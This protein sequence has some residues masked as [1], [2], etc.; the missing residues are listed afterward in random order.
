LIAAFY[1]EAVALAGKSLAQQISEQASPRHNPPA[2]S[3]SLVESYIVGDLDVENPGNFLLSK[4]I[5]ERL[6]RIPADKAQSPEFL[7]EL[8]L[9]WFSPVSAPT[10]GHIFRALGN[11]DY[12]NAIVLGPAGVGKSFLIDQLAAMYILDI[13]PDY[14]KSELG[15]ESGEYEKIRKAFLGNSDIVLI[16]MDL[17]SQDNTKPGKPW[18]DAESRMKS[19][20]TGLFDA[21]KQ[22]Y[23]RKDDS[24]RRVGKRTIFVFDEVATLPELVQ[25]TMKKVLDETGFHDPEDPIH[26]VEDPGFSVVGFTTLDEYPLFTGGDSAIERRYEIAEMHEPSEDATFQI[27][28]KRADVEWQSLYGRN[29]SDDAI[30]LLISMRKLLFNPPLAMPASAIRAGNMLMLA[31]KKD[32]GTEISPRDAERFVMDKARLTDVWFD[33]P[34][35]EP[36]FHDLAERL[37]RKVI[38][39]DEVIDS[40]ARRLKAWA[41]A[42]FGGEVPVFILGGPTGSGK[43]TLVRA[44]N[45]ELFGHNGEHLM[46]SIGGATS[47]ALDEILAGSPGSDKLPL[48]VQALSNGK[49]DGIIVLNEGKDAS[50]F[51]LEKLKVTLESGAIKPLGRDP[52][53]RP[54]R[55]PI[56]ILGQWGEQAFA[57]KNDDEIDEFYHGLTQNEIEGFFSAGKDAKGEIGVVSP[58]VLGR[59]KRTG[60]IYVL[61]PVRYRMYAKIA[62]LLVG[63]VSAGMAKRKGLK[64]SVSPRLINLIATFAERSGEGTRG[65]GAITVDLTETAVSEAMDQGIARRDATL[66]LDVAMKDGRPLVV[67][68]QESEGGREVAIDAITL[69]RVKACEQILLGK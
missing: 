53:V 4:N 35:G 39:Q 52:R 1:G 44:L 61:R 38:D 29:I 60:G 66:K 3:A 46:F 50:T 2:K 47:G 14:L 58:A 11:T 40:I 33:G 5:E 56:F 8:A 30:K 55:F 43:D 7:R 69:L 9:S 41:R 34:H 16:N 6:S 19:V 62:E 59:A 17:L 54:L 67:V 28:R 18:P 21:A 37:K 13:Y 22:E 32:A 49:G 57:G 23:A 27:V 12:S 68:R 42:G 45:E 31:K 64:I 36:P 25:K 26:A 51:V 15:I 10:L 65:L 63:H 48:L 24:G 20:I